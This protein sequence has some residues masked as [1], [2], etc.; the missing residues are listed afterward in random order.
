M[1]C[2]CCNRALSDYEST[3]RSAESNE[4]LDMCM[5]C[6]DGMDISYI[7]RD[8]LNNVVEDDDLEDI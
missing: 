8:D 2:Y 1:R 6:L 5:K 3:I 7:G 4:F